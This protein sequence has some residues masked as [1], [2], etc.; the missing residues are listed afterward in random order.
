MRTCVAVVGLCLLA[1]Q[2]DAGIV[3]LTSITNSDLNNS[4]VYFHGDQYPGAGTNLTIGGVGFTLSGILGSATDT[5]VIASGNGSPLDTGLLSITAQANVGSI[6]TIINAAFPVAADPSGPVSIGTLTFS[7]S[8]G[9]SFDYDLS[10]GD[11]V[12]DHVTG[13]SSPFEQQAPNVFATKD[14][15]TDLRLDVQKI[16]LP[17]GFAG[18]TLTGIQLVNTDDQ[19]GNPFLVGLTTLDVGVSP[20]AVPEPASWAMMLAGF[21]V[22][23]AGLRARRRSVRFV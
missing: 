5:G 21:G 2:A 22:I 11:N 16:D 18:L 23:G 12:R 19:D 20:G 15:G 4:G 3:D 14:F 6:Y 1:G 7:F 10:S 17:V 8:N 13:V 9:T